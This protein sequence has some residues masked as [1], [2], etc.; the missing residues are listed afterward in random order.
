MLVVDQR[1]L[2]PDL[3]AGR[4]IER[5]QAAI[6]GA[7]EDLALVERNAAIHDVAAAAITLR[8]VDAGVVG[9][10]LLAGSRVDRMD[11]APRRGHIHDAL[12]HHRRRLD[13]AVRSETVAPLQA[14]RL[15]VVGIDLIELAESGL[16]VIEPVAR[17]I[18][19]GLGIGDDCR[20]VDR[21]GD[22]ADVFGGALGALRQSASMQQNRDDGDRHAG[23]QVSAGGSLLRAVTEESVRKPHR[24]GRLFHAFT[25]WSASNGP[26]QEFCARSKKRQPERVRDLYL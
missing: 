4:S 1:I 15:D 8:P 17:P 24:L 3:R 20:A 13:T 2:L 18:V 19:G 7:D 6:I 21:A 14:E 5:N 25:P 16:G 12:D 11:D 23:A 22:R 26:D 10:E 9:P